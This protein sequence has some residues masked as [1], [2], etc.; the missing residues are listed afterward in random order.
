MSYLEYSKLLVNG[1]YIEV[2]PSIAISLNN[3]VAN[4]K[5]PE[6]I[7]IKNQNGSDC[8]IEYAGYYNPSLEVP[9]E[10]LDDLIEERCVY[11]DE[12]DSSR[13]IYR[14]VAETFSA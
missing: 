7:K 14:P 2:E 10:T 5:T 12:A 13:I 4:I 11:R 1:R 6:K 8:A 9:K 3:G